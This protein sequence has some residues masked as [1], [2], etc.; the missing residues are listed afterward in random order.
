MNVRLRQAAVAVLGAVLCGVMVLLGLWQM[1]VFESQRSDSTAARAAGAPVDLESNLYQG[2]VGD[3]YGRRVTASGSYVAGADQLVGTAYPLRVVSAF[4]TT[5]G[6][7]LAVVR[8]T[9]A[10]GQSVPA[11][12]TGRRTV[13]GII[14][15]SESETA[16]P[17]PAHLPAGTRPTLQLQELVQSWAPPL[18][19]GYVT[20]PAADSAAQ[21]LGEAV[22]KVPDTEGGRVRNQGYALQWW[23]FAAFGAAAT[24]VGVRQIGRSARFE[25]EHEAL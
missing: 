17:S 19:D 13:G 25:A 2:R 10:E 18:L 21:G 12:P 20:L 11:A 9:V 4:R 8:G 14:L 23:A 3:L 24:V 22:A 15:P 1:Q 5:G 16:R 6:R 7:T